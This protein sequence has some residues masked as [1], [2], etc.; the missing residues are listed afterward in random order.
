[1]LHES[2]SAVFRPAFSIIVPD[3]IFIVGIRIF[4][5]VPLDQF[6]CLIAGKLEEDI[7]VVY[8]S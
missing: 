2:H 8:V 4:S 3:D 5:E 6:P 7:E 1:M